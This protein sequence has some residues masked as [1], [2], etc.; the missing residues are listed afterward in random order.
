[1]GFILNRMREAEDSVFIRHSGQAVTYRSAA[2]GIEAWLLRLPAM[3]IKPGEV[4]SLVGRF[5]PDSTLLLLALCENGNIVVPLDDE[6]RENIDRRNT[7]ACAAHCLKRDAAGEI[8]HK[9][10]TAGV[11]HPLITTLTES[12]EAGVILFTSGS[13]GESKAA[14]HALPRMLAKYKNACKKKPY[15][16]L[17]FLKFDH[18]GGL[19]TLF[20]VLMHGGTMTVVEDRSPQAVCR[21]IQDEQVEILPTT[22]SFLTM[23][24][25]SKVCDQ[26]D[27]SSLKTITYGTEPMP[28][29]TLKSLFKLFPKVNIKQTYGLTELGI[30]PTRSRADESTFMEIREGEIRTR[31]VNGVLHIKSDM[32]MLGYLNAESPFDHEGW[33][34]TGDKVV[35][36]D[37]FLKILGRDSEII[38]VAGE[39]VFPAEVESVLL[40]MDNV[41]DVAVEGK[42]SPITGQIVAAVFHLET[43]ED[44]ASLRRR[45]IEHCRGR[46]EPFKVP[47]YVGI[48][49]Y[50][51]VSNRLKKSRRNLQQTADARNG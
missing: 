37:G 19:N 47:R 20:S 1:M 3:G 36:E 25:M 35:V 27:L 42:S 45:M 51:L 18:I 34:N 28:E 40:D 13:T 38:N 21:Q 5:T 48:S 22:P 33:Y 7:I 12:G 41:I 43:E 2:E 29:Y 11:T 17:V 44:I 49:D 26:Y 23:L 6:T 50:G 16:I 24:I 15:N 39:K 10:I 4:V 31:I 8:H 14:V 9:P 46:L 30:F 32:A